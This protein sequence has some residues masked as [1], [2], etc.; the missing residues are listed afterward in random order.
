MTRATGDFES[1]E[2]EA[3]VNAFIAY[4]STTDASDII[5]NNGAVAMNASVTWDAIK[6]NHPIT[7]SNNENITLRFGGSDSIQKIAI[8]LTSAFKAK[9]GNFVA[10]HDHRFW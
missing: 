9:A 5:N 10:E 1:E 6:D 7:N 3:L 4:L 8:A 2:V